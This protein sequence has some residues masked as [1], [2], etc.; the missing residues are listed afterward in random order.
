M[1]AQF[2]TQ[3]LTVV[4]DFY[5]DLESLTKQK[6]ARIVLDQTIVKPLADEDREFEV[7]WQFH[8]A[9]LVADPSVELS[10]EEMFDAFTRRY[11]DPG[12]PHIEEDAFIFLLS[13]MENPQPVF[14]HG[15]WTGCRLRTGAD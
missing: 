10:Q 9:M 6:E 8:N 7:I 12:Q 15:R 11:S 14:A 2:I 5:R 13:L 4:T 3:G 1:L